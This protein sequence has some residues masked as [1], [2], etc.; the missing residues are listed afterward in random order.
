MEGINMENE[1]YEE[2]YQRELFSEFEKEGIIVNTEQKER[3]KAKI[4][5]ITSYKPKIGVFGKTGVGKSSLCNALFGK[6]IAPI[7]DVAA[8]TRNPQEILLQIGE[9]KGINL[10]DVPGVGES[11]IR[12]D[13][14]SKLYQKLL[15]ELDLVLWVLKADDRAFATDESFYKYIVKPHLEQ[16]KPFLIVLNQVDKVAP[17]REWNEINRSPGANQQENISLIKE[18]VLKS[19][20][21]PKSKIID[22]SAEEKY[23]LVH[24]VD[25]MIFS[26]PKDKKITVLTKI[27]KEFISDVAKEDANKGFI[28][29]IGENLGGAIG[30]IFGEKGREIG[31]KIGRVI[32]KVGDL[33][34]RRPRFPW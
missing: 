14:Y 6:D 11:K 28:E 32:G 10:I 9:G 26:L 18:N 1:N 3:I 34:L 8:C 20:E 7:S 16:G 33:V 27:N 17:L 13:E 2:Y 22:I 23:N 21:Y 30:G 19:F 5:A 15:P 25:E 4:N 31:E 12:D 24:L 29:T